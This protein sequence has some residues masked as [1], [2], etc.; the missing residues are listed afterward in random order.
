MSFLHEKGGARAKVS[1][2]EFRL[3]KLVL[4]W[5]NAGIAHDAMQVTN[6]ADIKMRHHLNC[7]GANWGR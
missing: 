5:R 3:D 7:Y 6:P 1:Y 4:E 2:P